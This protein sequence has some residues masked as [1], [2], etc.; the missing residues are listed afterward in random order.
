[1]GNRFSMENKIITKDFFPNPNIRVLSAAFDFFIG[2]L[3]L[4]ILSAYLHEFFSLTYPSVAEFMVLY[5]FVIPYLTN[6]QTLGQYIFRI[7]TVSLISSKLSFYQLCARQVTFWFGLKDTGK[8]NE[9]NQQLQD[10]LFYTT[11]IKANKYNEFNALNIRESPKMLFKVGSIFLTI[12]VL[13]FLLYK[14]LYDAL[15]IS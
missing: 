4:V 15:T 11:I 7:K 9:R 13:V 12:F 6:G 1:M 14:G 2:L 5:Y 8:V 3:L 10:I